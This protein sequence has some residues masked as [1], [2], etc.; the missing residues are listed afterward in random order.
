MTR[1][2]CSATWFHGP[3]LFFFAP[4]L[5]RNAQAPFGLVWCYMASWVTAVPKALLLDATRGVQR[6]HD[7]GML[8]R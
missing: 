3:K 8:H 5:L 6:M 7:H 1:G 2:V 4:W